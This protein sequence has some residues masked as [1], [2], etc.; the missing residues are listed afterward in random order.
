MKLLLMV[1]LQYAGLDSIKPFGV[2]AKKLST[3]FEF[4]KSFVMLLKS[5]T[6]EKR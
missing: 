6:A 1:G 3:C 5:Q 2:G 4:S